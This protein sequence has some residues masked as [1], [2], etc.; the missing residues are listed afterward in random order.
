MGALELIEDAR[1][2]AQ[3]LPAVITPTHLL[4]MA[5]ERNAPIDQMERLFAL[6]L[7]VDAD[8]ARRAFNTA[9]AAFKAENVTVLRGKLITDGP[10]KDKR[11]AE[12]ID[13]VRGSTAA[14]SAHGLSTSWRVIE[15]AKDWI[16]V[17]CTLKHAAGHAESVALGGAPDTGPGRNAIQ[18]RGSVITYL[19]RYTLM[20]ILGLAASDVGDDDGV[21][22]AADPN[23]GQPARRQGAAPE[24]P[25][26]PVWPD[27]KFTARMVKWQEA[28]NAGA[29][30]DQIIDFANTKGALTD[31]QRTAIRALKPAGAP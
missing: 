27:D 11:H 13:V 14:L 16:R 17:E 31:A 5:Y 30:H 22:G 20:A 23:A 12:L 24:E 29:T 9:F 28:V 1:P 6:K 10:L 4:A 3:Q 2:T 19:Q 8:E 18:A 21:G 25:E 26:P 7:Q 15:D